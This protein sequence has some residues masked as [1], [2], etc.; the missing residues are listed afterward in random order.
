VALKGC[1]TERR[2]TIAEAFAAGEVMVAA[3]SEKVLRHM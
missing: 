1:F 3:N 2:R